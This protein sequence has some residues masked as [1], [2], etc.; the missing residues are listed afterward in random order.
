MG[1]RTVKRLL[2]LGAVFALLSGGVYFLWGHQVERM[3]RGVVARADQAAKDGD[4]AKAAQLYGEHL[5]VVPGDVEVQLK[6]AEVIIK[7]DRSAKRLGQALAGFEG[8][9]DRDASRADVRQ[10]AAEVALEIGGPAMVARARRHLEIL[11]GTAKFDGHLEYLL[12]RCLEQEGEFAGENGAEGLYGFAIEHEAP[13]RLEAAQHL[14]M[15][16]R[17]KLSKPAEADRVIDAMVKSAPDDYRVYLG[18]GR[19]REGLRGGTGGGDDFRKALQLAP[20][21]DRPKVYQDLARAVERESGLDAGRRVLKE[22]L[23]AAPKAIELYRALANLEGRAGRADQAAEALELGLKAVPDQLDLRWQLAL[24]LAERGNNPGRLLLLID[25][26]E[27]LGAARPFTQYLKAYHSF[28]QHEFIK[29]RQILAPL[30]SDVASIPFLKAKVN[31]L[32]SRCYN[33][34]N[35]P[36]LAREAMVRAY[37][38]EPRDMTARLGWIQDLINRGAIDEAIKE[39]QGLRAEQPGLVRLPLAGLLIRRN[40]RRP[41]AQRQ[42][43]EVEKLIGDAAA[44]APGSVEPELLRAET[45]LAQG[46]EEAALGALQAARGVSPRT[47]G[48]GSARP[49][50][51]A[52]RSGSARRRGC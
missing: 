3:A 39:Y 6:Y 21:D 29:A 28:D 18:R 27:R 1:T 49:G 22:G 23:T 42:W 45:L 47:P 41:E 19:Y 13:E 17:D 2:I 31:V 14:A 26:L 5:A 12:A 46:R 40:L 44:A 30:Q 37:D 8:V 34:S 51:W 11:K 38:A 15:L 25:E 43:G 48:P 50:C 7:A 20:A 10:R 9:L 32:L 33:E 4:F 52:G 35:E 36:D 24:L 16:L